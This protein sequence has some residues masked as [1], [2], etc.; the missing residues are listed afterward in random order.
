M[1]SGP[2]NFTTYLS[3]YSVFLSSIAGVIICDYYA[4]RKGYLQVIDLY[5]AQSTG[6]YWYTMGVNWRAY[7][8]YIC[9]I[10]INV[11]GFAGAVGNKVP[12]GATYVYR[13]NFFT[14][15]IASSSVYWIL[16]HFFKV[17]ATAD[18]FTEVGDQLRNPS[19]VH[20]TGVPVYDEE[21]RN[22]AYEGKEKGVKVSPWSESPS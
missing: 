7:V 17:P 10:L 3:S 14:G 22:D 21:Y 4:V 13:L 15:F 9:G 12:M 18:S 2:S 16:C 19:L 20:S 11:V 1:V 5:S 8:A 6:P